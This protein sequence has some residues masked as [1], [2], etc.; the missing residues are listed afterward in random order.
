MHY[1]RWLRHGDP[2]V[3]KKRA[4]GSQPPVCV[5]DGCTTKTAAKNMCQKH[6]KRAKLH[7]D[8][9][10][11]LTRS[12][13]VRQEFCTVDGCDR[14]N[15]C[16]G[17]CMM[18]YAR[19]KRTGTVEP[20]EKSRRGADNPM[21]LGDDITYGA[22]HRRIWSWRGRA[23]GH[24]CVD[25]EKPAAVWSLRHQDDK[26]VILV[27]DRNRG[28]SPNPDDYDPRCASCH[29]HYDHAPRVWVSTR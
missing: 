4:N 17:Y 25:C 9:T 7:G 1:A 10:V 8:V 20:S 19:L 21:W 28:Y 14:R 18:H 13:L 23:S 12:G 15:H 3:V 5:V 6:Y 16:R 2:L 11:T 27:D 24:A 26:V 22:A 29:W